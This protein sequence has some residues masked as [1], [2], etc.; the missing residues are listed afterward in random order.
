MEGRK[1]RTQNT[2]W[3][4]ASRTLLV[5]FIYR[6][7]QRFDN[8]GQKIQ[9]TAFYLPTLISKSCPGSLCPLL[10]RPLPK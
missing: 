10:T 4:N 1:E 9:K 7:K 5:V 3:K 6:F 2:K 8:L